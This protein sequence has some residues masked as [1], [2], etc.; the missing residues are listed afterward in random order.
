MNSITSFRL[1]GLPAA[2]LLAGIGAVA[3][4][5]TTSLAQSP[6]KAASPTNPS[7]SKI[8]APSKSETPDSAFKKLDPNAKGYVSKDDTAQFPG[9]D[10]AFRRADV[11]NDGRLSPGEF[12]QAWTIYSGNTK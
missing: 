9:F 5:T 4:T 6:E 3:T 8:V 11:N 10:T 7:A 12:N 2:L 1:R